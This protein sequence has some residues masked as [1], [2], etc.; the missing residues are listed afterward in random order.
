M[1][2]PGQVLTQL[3]AIFEKDSQADRIT[4]V[5]PE[6]LAE[7]VTLCEMDGRRLRI[8]Y[9]CS[10]LAI[11][12]QLVAHGE[13]AADDALRL[14]ILSG[15]DQAR[16]A[17]DVLAR[18]WRN[19]PQRISPWRTLQQILAVRQLDPR[20]T[21][22]DY[23]WIAEALL[24]AYGDYKDRVQFGEVL[25][26]DKAWQA[27][28]CSLLGFVNDHVDLPSLFQWSL[29]GGCEQ[30]YAALPQE[31]KEHIG[32][33]LRPAIPQYE[34]LLLRILQKGRADQLL[35]IGLACSV[36]YHSEL[37]QKGQPARKGQKKLIDEHCLLMGRAVF[38]ERYLGG[39]FA[40]TKALAA[41]GREA[42]AFV[43]QSL[44]QQRAKG[45][46]VAVAK[47]FFDQF[48]AAEQI[49]AALDLTPLLIC[50]HILPAGFRLRLDAMA[51]ALK[52]E[53]RGKSQVKTRALLR[54]LSG[55]ISSYSPTAAAQIMRATMAVRLC[56][57]LHSDVGQV[58][59][60]RSLLPNYIHQ[61][62]FAD[63]ARSKI[64]QG[65]VHEQLGHVYQKLSAQ[66]GRRCEQHNE[67]FASLLAAVARGEP[68]K[69]LLLA[70]QAIE[71]L[72]APLAQKHRV[73]LLVLDGMSQA[74]YRELTE[75]LVAQN[76]V[77]WQNEAEPVLG[78]I[79]TLPS[80]TKASRCS[81]FSGRL[82]QG[83]AADE[84]RFF[85]SH[86]RLKALAS[87]RYPP[88]LY[89][90]SDLE[91]AGSGALATEVRATLAGTE[92][93]ITAVVINAI[94]DQLSN[95]AQLTVTWKVDTIALLRQVIDAAQE[96]ER[97]VIL[98]SDHGHVLDCAM[99]KQAQSEG[100]ERYKP[101]HCVAEQGEVK[102]T[103][104]RVL[105]ED[106]SV[107]LPWSEKIRYT[108][109]KM[110]YHGGGSLQ[111]VMIP[112]GIYASAG[113][114]QAPEGWREVPSYT[115]DWWHG[116]SAHGRASVEKDVTVQS[117]ATTIIMDD[118]F[119]PSKSAQMN[120]WVSCD[121]TSQLLASPVYQQ[122][123]R[124]AGQ[125]VI[126]DELLA[127]MLKFLA[128]NDCQLVIP[129]L[130]QKLGIPE[131]R[132]RGFLVGAQKLLNVDGY[133]IL[134]IDRVSETVKLNFERVKTEF[135]LRL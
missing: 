27:L 51:E 62:G 50:S 72:V 105:A 126:N 99:P 79:S 81:L 33:W 32:D 127:R 48:D 83:V 31:M 63:W 66:V 11:R 117:N 88:R 76:W 20:L 28:S 87:T 59:E 14:V 24:S 52:Q 100:G 35:A 45:G 113:M 58:P 18:I 26:Q 41:F 60:G 111:E 114:A 3:Q 23:H 64:W 73:L 1:S 57:W 9:C 106:N 10:E 55:H 71:G 8:V 95:N 80:I 135:E 119:A 56:E 30:A 92:H 19:E 134:A 109:R 104:A 12:E 112:L 96:G 108:S 43:E 85:A 69:N 89:H 34:P 46:S 115:P 47:P 132:M 53:L 118:M 82:Q 91:Q 5:W 122:A 36:I 75:D 61:G 107:V 44:R 42:V 94:D 67:A 102:L 133:S 22:P 49:L 101:G 37:S 77:E 130:V 17:N 38:A 15:I 110:G 121:W 2:I 103:G 40:D 65:D 129:L 93:R 25:D 74:V 78:L 70:E 84:K 54:G 120:E 4:L 86:A 98:T 21:R 128:A 131:P 68:F 90:K 124:R 125:T 16:L 29:R 6:P 7:P 123:K 39:R 97:V 116:R 13:E